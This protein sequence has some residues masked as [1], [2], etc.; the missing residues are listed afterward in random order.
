MDLNKAINERH[1][2]RKFT[3]KKPDWRTILECIDSARFAPM[4]GNNYTAKFIL[5][6]DREK[7]EKLTEACQQPFVGEAH[8]IV[9]VC[10]IKRGVINAYGEQ[11]E[12]FVRQQAG[13]AIQNFLL[14]LTEEG[15]A[16]CW[17]GYFA[18]EQVR[19]ILKIPSKAQVEALFPVGYEFEKK[20]AKTEKIDLDTI[21]YFDIYGNKRMKRITKQEV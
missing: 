19:R 13:A 3:S 12:T 16:T 5:V 21:M 20:H 10:S 14:R 7:I 15:L 2:T 17:I 18:E 4:A 11:A 8:Y 1:S 9:V 6:D